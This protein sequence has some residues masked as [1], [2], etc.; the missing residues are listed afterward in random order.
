MAKK[1]VNS[2]IYNL[3]QLVDDVKSVYIPDETDETLAIGTYG[4]IGALESHRLQTQ[5]Q[6]T[7][8]LSNEV[9]PSRARLE[10]NIITHAIMANIDDINAVPSKMTAFFAIRENDINEYFN[11]STN[12][13][14]IDRECPIYIGDYE[15]HLEYDINLQ[16]IYLPAK[17]KNTYTAWYNIP[18]NRDVPTSTVTS[19]NQYLSPP[20]V[21]IV[22][23]EAYI[24]LT[25]IL[26]QVTHFNETKKLVTSNI[27]DNKTMN[28]EFEDQL[29][30]FEIH[31]IESNEDYYI[32]P[33]FEGSSVPTDTKSQYYCW[34]QYIDTNLIR[35]RFDRN[36]YMPGLNTT[37]ECLVKTCKGEEGNF[38]YNEDVYVD[39]KSSI[40]GYKNITCLLTPLSD[41]EGGKDRKSKK[42]L[43]SLIPKELLSRG[44]LTT[45]TDLNN[46]FSMLDSEYGRIVIQKKI[47]NQ[48]ER[49]YYAYFVAKDTNN[50]IIP[51]NTIDIKVG[52]EDLTPSSI[53]S[54][55]SKRY[56]LKS[57]KC[58][59]FNN[60]GIGIV[61][62]EPIINIGEVFY[63]KSI[64]R[65]KIIEDTFKL[66][67]NSDEYDAVSCS[68]LIGDS[69][70]PVL[71]YNNN[72]TE[73]ITYE[74]SNIPIEA[75]DYLQM[76]IGG[77]YNF[78]IDY[79]TK[80][81][82]SSILLKDEALECFNFVEGY[83]TTD[84]DPETKIYFES[85]PLRVSGL[86]KD[87]TIHINI[88]MRL[89]SNIPGIASFEYDGKSY[90]LN[91]KSSVYLSKLLDSFDITGVVANAEVSD[92]TILK[93]E[94]SEKPDPEPSP[95]YP[96][97][98]N[99]V[100]EE[101]LPPIES[102]TKNNW[103]YVVGKTEQ[104]SESDSENSNTTDA[105]Y[106]LHVVN[107]EN[108]P[109][110]EE[111]SDNNWY[112]AVQNSDKKIEDTVAE[113]LTEAAKI[114]ESK[115]YKITIL[116]KISESDS[117]NIVVTMNDG[118]VYII[119]MS[120]EMNI[121]KDSF[122][123]AEFGY[124]NITNYTMYVPTLVQSQIQDDNTPEGYEVNHEITYTLRY[125]SIS[126]S[127]NPKITIKISR[128]LEYK[129][130]SNIISYEGQTP[131]KTE[132]GEIDISKEAGFLYTNPYAVN[133]NEYR[134]YSSF[135]MMSINEN[136]YIH[137]SWIND[138]SNLQFI[139]TNVEW[140]RC[141]LGEENNKYN[142]KI[143]V[144]Q[145]VQEDLGLK[146]Y[147]AVKAVA[148]FRRDNEDYRY[149]SMK[150]TGRDE[151]SFI[152]EQEFI[153][154][155]IFDNNNNIKVTNCQIDGQAEYMVKLS[156]DS[157]EE[158]ISIENG[159]SI[160]LSNLR[161]KFNL[162]G[163]ITE[164]YAED[165]NGN[166][167]YDFAFN[168]TLDSNSYIITESIITSTCD[169]IDDIKLCFVMDD[170]S[171][172]YVKASCDNLAYTEYG[173]FNPIS[174]LKIYILCGIPD[175]EGT[176]SKN[177]FDSIYPGL[178]NWT[179]TNIYDVVNGVTFFHNYSEIMGSRVV[180]YGT[181]SEDDL[182]N[183][184]IHLEGYYIYNIPMIG[185]DYCQ[186]ESLIQSAINGLNY[187]KTYIDNAMEL[188]EN[189]FGIDF[190]LFN[191]YGPSKTYYIMKDSNNNNILD[192]SKEYI[193]RVNI[194]LNF[195]VKLISSN[196]SYTKDNIIN[197]IKEYI[198]DLNDLSELH[199]PN[200]VSQITTA[201]Q[202][203]ITYFEYLGFNDYGPNVQHIYKDSDDEIG[204][205]IA[206][207][208][209]NVNSIIGSD[210]TYTPDINVYVSEI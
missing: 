12:I 60:D 122:E 118:E 179:L 115:E 20:M 52:L 186:N 191:T 144:T 49:V 15:F 8:E 38:K 31:C 203:Q 79:T 148:V 175:I 165:S 110:P 36:S 166:I 40:Y 55:D 39:L 126:N 193:D 209:I 134:L 53:S 89:N 116:K 18:G 137:F 184:V 32:L 181:E 75:E 183:K 16:R 86:R 61:N 173:F 162:D 140:N 164:I 169:F 141:F 30:Y 129:L 50:N 159:G 99:V 94:E 25:V 7:G 33:I 73:A 123:I 28:F 146:N 29:A 143:M 163:N 77:L 117:A 149:K 45:I 35:V 90:G 2:D 82:K 207:E 105:Q 48:I 26:T 101:D 63:T 56:L 34:Y 42:E 139:T 22:N 210:G 102:R 69:S 76:N 188:L 81:N 98:L 133:I 83:Y 14:T 78:K 185:Y 202:E 204:I 150:L 147:S 27:V 138:K 178:T 70:T 201:Y 177:G 199:I 87:L 59:R 111:R 167:S 11:S 5:V 72:E 9:F 161:N 182:G 113:E 95:E 205:H 91:Q 58:F 127:Y 68:V 153:S 37:V 23:N 132:P 180:P 44:S 145:S 74:E 136:P 43:Q 119:N 156:Q 85:I 1:T 168:N 21:V 80:T 198:E 66:V 131:Y 194:T 208:F 93:I 6:M 176:Y 195:R 152:F 171:V 142:L 88:N 62:H 158:I 120:L 190:K 100:N 125:R 107:Q 197:D 64:S 104:R 130:F 108:M 196:D 160:S 170:K 121:I 172:K 4:Y 124:T 174:D 103:F 96:Y 46:Y 192:D 47:D 112:Y 84:D 151:T 128:G 200:L 3:S 65:G 135:Y 54:T 97:T 67:M 154:E 114:T 19:D 157:S 51:S 206:P 17:K 92:S 71:I 13:F 155:D 10:R 57:G 187:R 24:Y 109:E 106:V 189:S 41:A